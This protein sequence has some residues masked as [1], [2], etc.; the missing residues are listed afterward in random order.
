MKSSTVF[1]IDPGASRSSRGTGLARAAGVGL[2]TGE[3]ARDILLLFET[4]GPR[5]I[6]GAGGGK[7]KTSIIVSLITPKRIPEICNVYSVYRRIPIL[8]FIGFS[9]ISLIFV[10]PSNWNMQFA[11]YKYQIDANL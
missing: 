5:L 3:S 2:E 10:V 1:A 9:S 7:Q 4:R 8:N 6:P 11:A